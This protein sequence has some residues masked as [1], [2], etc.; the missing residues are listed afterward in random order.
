MKMKISTRKGQVKIYTNSS[1]GWEEVDAILLGPFAINKSLT[2]DNKWNI[3][4]IRTGLSVVRMLASESLAILLARQ[5]LKD[6]PT[7]CWNWGEFG[8]STI[9]GVIPKGV[10]RVDYSNA[11]KAAKVKLG[12]AK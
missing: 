1:E 12:L 2:Y 11:I 8:S 4:H 5:L 10:S 9:E 6:N 3:T 7:L